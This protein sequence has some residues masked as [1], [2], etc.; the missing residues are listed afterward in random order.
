MPLLR[1]AFVH[2]KDVQQTAN[3]HVPK[4]SAGVNKLVIHYSSSTGEGE[5]P[6]VDLD[7]CNRIME[8]RKIDAPRRTPEEFDDRTRQIRINMGFH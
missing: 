8:L 2:F 7:H 4:G 3:A 5:L 1:F 6:R